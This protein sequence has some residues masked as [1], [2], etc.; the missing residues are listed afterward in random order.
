MAY[1]LIAVYIIGIFISSLV[2]TYLIS[3]ARQANFSDIYTKWG[4]YLMDFDYSS[5]LIWPLNFSWFIIYNILNIPNII[6]S[7]MFKNIK[8]SAAEKAE[9]LNKVVVMKYQ[10]ECRGE[11]ISTNQA[12]RLIKL[13][14]IQNK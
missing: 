6:L 5:N 10:Y 1:I 8:K 2:R 11:V 13:E 14:E 7:K 9:L 4:R 12:I 3:Y